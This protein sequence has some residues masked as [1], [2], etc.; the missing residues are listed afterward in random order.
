M[1]MLLCFGKIW[2]F[3]CG[4]S[5]VF[6]ESSTNTNCSQCKHDCV[7]CFYGL[8]NACMFWKNVDF[9]LFLAEQ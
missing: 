3:F 9:L 8:G 5:S 7:V 1:E 2:I 4:E 6:I